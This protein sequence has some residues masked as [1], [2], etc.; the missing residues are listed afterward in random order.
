MI[1]YV[2]F[3]FCTQ[4]I[5]FS[6]SLPVSGNSLCYKPH[7]NL[8]NSIIMCSELTVLV[9]ILELEFQSLVISGTWDSP[10]WYLSCAIFLINDIQI[11]FVFYQ[12]S[13]YH[14]SQIFIARK[15]CNLVLFENFASWL[16]SEDSVFHWNLLLWEQ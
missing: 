5:T 8:G 4:R 15:P 3:F 9:S 10:P 7:G 12:R 6:L 14:A 13:L 16:L 11:S 2:F 1:L